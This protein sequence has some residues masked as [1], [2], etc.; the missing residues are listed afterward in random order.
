MAEAK[1]IQSQVNGFV[2]GLIT[3]AS[4]LTFPKD[5]SYDELNC[6]LLQTGNRRRRLGVDF[7]EDHI[8]SSFTVDN[9]NLDTMAIFTYTWKGVANKGDK[10]FLCVQLGD[11]IYFYD[12]S[13]DPIFSG[14]KEFTID[15]SDYLSP[16]ATVS[17]NTR[18]SFA[19]GKGALFIAS[20]MIEV[21]KVEY[22][23]EA[24]DIT[25]EEII[26][27]I[28]DF[29]GVE[30][31]LEVDE[32]PNTLS[33]EHEYNLK[34]QGWAVTQS[35]Y[36]PISDYYSKAS[37]YPGNN[38][39]WTLSTTTNHK[40]R[41]SELKNFQVGTTQ[42]PR[43]HYILEAFQKDRSTVS[44]V[45]GIP[46]EV[47]KEHPHAVGFFSGRV[48]YLNGNTVYISEVL[49]DRLSNAGKCYQ[50]ADP[51]SE[52]ISDLVDTDGLTIPIVQASSLRDLSVV[53]STLYIF[54][55]NG[56]WYISGGQG[57][58][59]ATDF[60]VG[61]ISDNGVVAHDSV[62]NVEGS[63]IWV[64]SNGIYT[65]NR[66]TVSGEPIPV[67][68]TDNT[69]KTFFNNIP[70][71]SLAKVR[72]VYDRFSSKIYWLYKDS[73]DAYTGDSPYYYNNALIFDVNLKAF[74]P[75]KISSLST[76]SPYICGCFETPAVTTGTAEDEV[77]LS[78]GESVT[79][80]NGDIVS[81]TYDT[82]IALNTGLQFITLIPSLVTT[83]SRLGFSK[84]SNISLTDWEKYAILQGEDEGADYDSYLETGFE[85][86]G[87]VLRFKQAPYIVVHC[88]RTET[89]VSYDEND[90][91][92]FTLPSSLFLRAKWDWSSGSQSGKWSTRQQAYRLKEQFIPDVTTSD[93]DNGRY[94]TSTKL[95]IRGNGRAL[96]LRF[97]SESGK[98]FDIVGW[99]TVFTGTTDN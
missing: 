69:I 84:F 13:I 44:G 33:A 76:F 8:A 34:N 14:L 29:D 74:Y 91:R 35:G 87:D 43:G 22:D 82:L 68:L 67:S 94:L 25:V 40:L 70:S 36:D 73:S 37:K 88:K 18:V 54:A 77:V 98:D 10:N 12:F 15:L 80:T 58:F 3:E 90:V 49:N 59:K 42:A 95:R 16:Y 28:R 61:K 85:I 1:Q 5:A 60:S 81:V 11:I 71:D 55:E 79:L 6:I 97:E 9:T 86:Q 26:I 50:D 27:K 38:L 30:D 47:K 41:Y 51:T 4:E 83:T 23:E 89:G 19:S 75:W 63:P 46:Q 20:P 99:G 78:D 93:W 39:Q 72:G 24:D 92:T 64:S 57:G 65:V 31:G 45:A 62:V 7:L 96:Q 66:D 2:K 53:G 56:V 17:K 48:V 32:Y 21:L 52:D